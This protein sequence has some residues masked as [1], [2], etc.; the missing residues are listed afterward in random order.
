[1]ESLRAYFQIPDDDL[2]AS[3]YSDLLGSG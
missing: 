1:L 3:S 2:M